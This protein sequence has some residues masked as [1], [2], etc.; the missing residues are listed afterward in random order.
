MYMYMYVYIHVC[1]EHFALP[2]GCPIELARAR[3]VRTFTFHLEQDEL[4]KEQ[5]VSMSY[6]LETT[7][8][9]MTHVQA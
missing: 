3:L 5:L 2:P 4:I 6:W 9:C 1:I 7:K 8:L